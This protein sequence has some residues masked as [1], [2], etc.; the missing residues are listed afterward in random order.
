[1]FPILNPLPPPSPIC[2]RINL[3]KG[4]VIRRGVGLPWNHRG[5][6]NFWYKPWQSPQ[7]H[8]RDKEYRSLLQII[9]YHPYDHFDHWMD[10]S[11]RPWLSYEMFGLA[12]PSVGLHR[13]GH[14]W[15]T[16]GLVKYRSPCDL[17]SQ[18][19]CGPAATAS[20]TLCNEGPHHCLCQCLLILPFVPESRLC[21][22]P[23]G[24]PQGTDSVST[25]GS[26]WN[27][28]SLWVWLRSAPQNLFWLK[29]SSYTRKALH[30]VMAE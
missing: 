13:V 25:C 23:S 14:D 1:M 26:V 3:F 12:Y 28:F 11:G 9:L 7:I 21:M 19:L 20:L 22:A 6:R 27:Y 4:I 24:W 17:A 2:F 16:S 18:H 10:V 5:K 29:S 30:I 8:M 15:S